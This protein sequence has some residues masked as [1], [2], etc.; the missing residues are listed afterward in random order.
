METERAS[1]SWAKNTVCGLGLTWIVVLAIRG[2]LP[3][4]HF[5]K[6]ARDAA[7]SINIFSLETLKFNICAEKARVDLLVERGNKKMRKK[8]PDNA[9]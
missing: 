9:I 8:E 2:V 7:R 1:E 3:F 5:A 6:G 4:F